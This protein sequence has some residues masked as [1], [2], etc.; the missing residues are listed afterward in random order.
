MKELGGK[1]SC[2]RQNVSEYERS[3]EV[4]RG[5]MEEMVM[6]R[7]INGGRDELEGWR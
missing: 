1:M 2:S 7:G 3:S 6:V 5:C 4:E